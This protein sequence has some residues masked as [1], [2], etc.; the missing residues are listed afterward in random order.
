MRLIT[1]SPNFS[2]KH[3]DYSIR[4]GKC[5]LNFIRKPLIL[6]GFPGMWIMCIS[7]S[8]LTEN[9]DFWAKKYPQP[10]FAVFGEKTVDIVDNY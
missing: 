2:F 5:K 10:F 9:P 3:C 7:R 1:N 6:L 4:N 8:V